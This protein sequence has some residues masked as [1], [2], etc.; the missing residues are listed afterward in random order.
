[1]AY[2][3]QPIP[4][5]I[6]R[7]S[8]IKVSDGKSVNVTVPTKTGVVAGNFYIIDGF[9]GAAWQT[10]DA[11][12]N[13]AG[14]QI[15]L[16]LEACEYVTGQ[17]DTTRPFTLGS[18]LYFDSAKKVFTDQKPSAGLLVGRVSMAKTQTNVIQFIRY[19]H[20]TNVAAV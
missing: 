7:M 3:G 6:T 5:T 9:F 13:T 10:V 19:Q 1:M 17:I 16:Q 8:P 14:T 15:A 11:A 12:S 4:S 2:V 20:A 18:D